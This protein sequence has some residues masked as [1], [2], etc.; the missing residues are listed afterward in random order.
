[1]R[2]DKL[3]EKLI[4]NSYGVDVQIDI[5]VPEEIGTMVD[6]EIRGEMEYPVKKLIIKGKWTKEDC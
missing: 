1:M 4:M 2:F 3:I 5:E 6:W